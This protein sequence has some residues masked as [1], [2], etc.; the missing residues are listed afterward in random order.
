M[1]TKIFSICSRLQE[2]LELRDMKQ[3]DLV[4]KTHI[5]K[6]SISQYVTGYVEPK[7]ERIYMLAEALSVNP[8]WLMGYDVSIEPPSKP[9]LNIGEIL[10]LKRNLAGKTLEEIGKIVGVSKQT[11]QRYESGEITNIS[12]DKLMLLSKALGCN[13]ADFFPNDIVN[14][15]LSIIKDVLTNIPELKKYILNYDTYSE[16]GHNLIKAALKTVFDMEESNAH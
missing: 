5:P 10:K 4:E 8:I 11:I 9:N 2:A 14:S 7:S 3:N 12:Y 15:E 13:C 1:N 16:L 6:G